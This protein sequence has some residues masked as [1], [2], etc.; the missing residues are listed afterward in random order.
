MN[1]IVHEKWKNTHFIN[2]LGQRIFGGQSP[3]PIFPTQK[4]LQSG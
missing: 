2:I 1:L 4:S 3:I